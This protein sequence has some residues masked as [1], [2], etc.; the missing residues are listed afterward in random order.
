MTAICYS[1]LTGSSPPPHPLGSPPA[2]DVL[3]RGSGLIYWS[4][5]GLRAFVLLGSLQNPQ[6]RSAQRTGEQPEGRG[7]P[8]R[9]GDKVR[10]ETEEERRQGERG[11]EEERRQSER[12]KRRGD[13][14]REE[15]KRR[16]DKVREERE[17]ERRKC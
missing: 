14:M 13:K 4:S 7:Q 15:K 2:Q 9:R 17:E 12:G 6:D 5:R 10:E 3:T 8:T 1:Q 16:G 11:D